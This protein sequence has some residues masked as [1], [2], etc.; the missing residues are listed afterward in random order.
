MLYFWLTAA[1]GAIMALMFS[2]CANPVNVGSSS[3]DIELMA[4]RWAESAITDFGLAKGSPRE[5][6][7][8]NLATTVLKDE[9]FMAALRAK[10]ANVDPNEWEAQLESEGALLLDGEAQRSPARARHTS[11]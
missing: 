6:K 4:K 3:T 2:S 8:R 10:P 5:A 1:C 7:L 9:Y 11:S